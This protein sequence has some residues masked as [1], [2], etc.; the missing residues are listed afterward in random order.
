MTN[1][2]GFR[3]ILNQAEDNARK[4]DVKKQEKIHNKHYTSLQE[5]QL[6]QA[7]ETLQDL[8]GNEYYI[9]RKRDKFAK[10]EFSQVIHVTLLYLVKIKY[11]TTSEK[12]LLLDL[13]LFLEVGTNVLIEKN[14]LDNQIDPD[15]INSASVQYLANELG[16]QREALS[17]MM[18]ILKRKGILAC[19]ESGFRDETGRIC[20][21]RTW[22]MNPNI[23]CCGKKERIDKVTKHIFKDILRNFKVEGS[24]EI[25]NLPIYFF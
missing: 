3:Q 9:G 15:A 8:T 25:H 10:V 18:K 21:K 12:A 2:D 16:R 22:L 4:R 5:E 7:L 14:I 13:M 24:S 20:T 17:K 1:P 11:L 23:I 6:G 19:A